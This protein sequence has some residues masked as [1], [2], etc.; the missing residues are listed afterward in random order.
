M[1][2]KNGSHVATYATGMSLT[3]E[4]IYNQ[5]FEGTITGIRHDSLFLNG[6]PFHY[7][8][9]K[10][11][12]YE[13]TKLNYKTDGVILMIAGAGVL[14]LGAVN[15]LYR[16]DPANEWYTTTSYITAGTLL[17]GGFILTKL[18]YKKYEIGKKYSLQYMELNPNKNNRDSL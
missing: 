11:I 7:K 3:M 14:L 17:V 4:T 2:Q 12:R 10:T 5:W 18:Q 8:E 13:R 6:M 1:L 15:G 9:I 16:G